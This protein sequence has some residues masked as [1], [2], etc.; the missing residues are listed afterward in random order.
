MRRI[1]WFVAFWLLGVGLL[2]LAAWPIRALLS[3]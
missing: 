3:G 1:L 2:V